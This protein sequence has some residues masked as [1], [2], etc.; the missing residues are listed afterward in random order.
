VPYEDDAGRNRNQGESREAPS[1]AGSDRAGTAQARKSYPRPDD[2]SAATGIG[3]NVRHDVR[4]VNLDLQPRPIAEVMM[5]YEYREALVRLGIIPRHY[6]RQDALR[7][8]ER[9]TGFEDRGF[10]PEP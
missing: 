3:R 6:S 10:S 2:E 7:R 5:R 9:S 4:W 8:R 1:S